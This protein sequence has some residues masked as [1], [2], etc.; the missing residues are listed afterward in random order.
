MDHSQDP[1]PPMDFSAPPPPTALPSS[2]PSSPD[3]LG[4]MEMD[5]PAPVQR[6]LNLPPAAASATS[7]AS[8]IPHKRTTTSRAATPEAPRPS[9]F[10]FTGVSDRPSPRTPIANSYHEAIAMARS[11]L[12]QASAMA[13]SRVQESQALDLLEVFR[14]FTE[15]GRINKHGVSMLAS[16]VSNLETVSRSLGSKVKQLQKPSPTASSASTLPAAASSH[17]DLQATRPPP[18]STP[19]PAGQAPSSRSYAAAAANSQPKPTDWQTVA[20]KKTPPPSP[21][22]AL[23]TRQL[24]LIKE[25]AAPFNSLALRNAF[26]Q[27]FANKGVSSPVVASVTSSAKQNMV[28]TTTPAFT[29]KYLLENLAIWKSITSFKEALP[30]QP[31]FKVAVHNIPTSFST[32][33]SLDILKSEITTFNKGFQIVGSPYWLTSRERRQV[34]QTGSVCIAFATEQ[35]AQ[36]AIRSRL[37]LL[38]ISVRVE[39]MHSTP[40]S[41]Q[42][43]KCQRFGHSESRCS[44]AIACKICADPHPTSLHKCNT[45]G[46]KGRTCVHTVPV[47]ANCKGAHTADNKQCDTYTATRP[48][49]SAS[50]PA[51]HSTAPMDAEW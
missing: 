4:D 40:A 5:V 32:N 10:H 1:G 36:R 51:S 50:Q 11:L 21:K 35:E 48:T 15:N 33:E 3:P 13:S 45:C 28:L 42:C 7:V 23:S 14:D 38:G 17:H 37:Y 49:H 20:K 29:A 46:A 26:N 43:Q 18:Q 8:T 44:N 6:I 25:E 30:I 39:K 34:Q 2:I 24:V 9:P 22:N 19:S 41:S 47:C 27:A 31:W 16:Q 12:I